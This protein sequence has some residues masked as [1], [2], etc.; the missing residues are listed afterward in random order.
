MVKDYTE[1]Q[2]VLNDMQ[3][4]L[5]DCAR[6]NNGIDGIALLLNASIIARSEV[7]GYGGRFDA[8]V[9]S[10]LLDNFSDTT[11]E[12]F[13]ESTSL[14]FVSFMTKDGNTQELTAWSLA[15]PF[16]SYRLV[17][18]GK[19]KNEKKLQIHQGTVPEYINE[20]LPLI[21]EYARLT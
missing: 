11:Q 9:A 5:N 18:T 13:G 10:S 15:F 7:E 17:F 2:E 6:A 14:E 4:I 1:A 19:L 21:K 12:C 16:N 8:K 3:P 20:L